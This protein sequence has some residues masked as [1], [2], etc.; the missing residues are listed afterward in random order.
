MSEKPRTVAT[1]GAT[2]RQVAKV[3]NQPAFVRSRGSAKLLTVLSE[4]LANRGGSP[5][6]QAE[7][8][9][10]LGLPDDFDP[11]R[12]PL[13]RI[14]VSKLRQLLQKYARTDGANA[15][16]SSVG[17]DLSH[18]LVLHM[19]EG[20][21]F[22]TIGPICGEHHVGSTP[23]PAFLRRFRVPYCVTGEI[24]LGHRGVEVCVKFI[25]L[26]AG[27]IFWTD[28][29]SDDGSPDADA[30]D[31][32]LRR[33]AER[34]AERLESMSFASVDGTVSQAGVHGLSGPIDAA[35]DHRRPAV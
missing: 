3:L 10:V 22:K 13:V 21:R 6:T 25:D 28:W 16:A 30:P 8:A 32:T 31:T 7:L 4:R 29:L 26:A 34:I 35:I 5:A 23:V 33:F 17:R 9:K 27:E 15:P 12:N 1:V 24:S 2:L 14:H 11:L 18:W 19:M 20:E